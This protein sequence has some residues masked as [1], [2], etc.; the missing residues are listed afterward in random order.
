MMMSLL[1]GMKAIKNANS[2]SKNKRRAN[3]H[4]LASNIPLECKTGAYQKTKRKGSQ[5][6][7][8]S[9][10]DSRFWLSA[11]SS[12]KSYYGFKNA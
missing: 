12:K 4:C 9:V 7:L 5:K 10:S 3:I 8:L 6:C 1:H 11:M 2:E